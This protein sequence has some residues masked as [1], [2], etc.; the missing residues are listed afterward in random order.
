MKVFFGVFGRGFCVLL[1][2]TEPYLFVWVCVCFCLC[3]SSQEWRGAGQ[4]VSQIPLYYSRADSQR[5]RERERERQA[6]AG[7][8]Q[9]HVF[10]Q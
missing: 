6:L 5:G 9:T 10:Y 1:H 8:R 3:S 4:L 7:P 2:V